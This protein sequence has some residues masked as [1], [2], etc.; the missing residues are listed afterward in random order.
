VAE[1][2]HFGVCGAD[3]AVPTLGNDATARVE[4]D[5]SDLGVFACRWPAGRKVEGM[6]HRLLD[7]W[8]LGHPVLNPEAPGGSS[9]VPNWVL[10]AM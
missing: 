3:A 9:V 10:N 5:T 7:C 4:E 1:R 6:A 2:I 8:S